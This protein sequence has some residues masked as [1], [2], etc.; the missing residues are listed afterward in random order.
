MKEFKSS[1]D[2]GDPVIVSINN[3]DITGNIR[4]VLFTNGEV[5]YSVSIEFD[6]DKTT[7]FHN[8]DS[9]FVKNDKY[10]TKKTTTFDNYS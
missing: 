7:T 3:V 10:G 4:K 2:I 8:I 6:T 5:R 9:M 1:Y